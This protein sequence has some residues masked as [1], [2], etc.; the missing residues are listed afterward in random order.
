MAVIFY[1]NLGADEVV[2]GIAAGGEGTI[3]GEV[4][5]LQLTIE[6]GHAGS[7]GLGREVIDPEAD[8]F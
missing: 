5:F 1:D 8:E 6:L 4:G 2:G 7:G 3:P